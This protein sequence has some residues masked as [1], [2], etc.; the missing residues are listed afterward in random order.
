[1]RTAFERGQHAAIRTAYE[2]GQQPWEQLMRKASSIENSLSERPAS[3]RTAYQR[4]QQHL[5]QLLR[6]D[7]S[8][9]NSLSER[10]ATPR[11]ARQRGQ[12]PNPE[13]SLSQRPAA[14]R[15]AR[16]RGQ[17]HWEQL[18]REASNPE[19]S[20]SERPATLRTARQ[21]G[22]QLMRDREARAATRTAY[23]RG[24]SS[25]VL[26][27]SSRPQCESSRS[28]RDTNFGAPK[29]WNRKKV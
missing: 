11:T 16:Q 12:Q 18:V 29:L 19:N 27:L 22:P 25:H 23:E 4:G 24:Q 2:I 15:T 9:E 7:C 8:T 1:M 20:L 26:P 10:P 6:E 21:R 28:S 14:L 5:E 17:Q 13:K 3:L